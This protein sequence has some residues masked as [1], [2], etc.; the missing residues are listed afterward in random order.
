MPRSANST[1]L[2]AMVLVLGWAAS[3][4][5]QIQD[6]DAVQAMQRR[7]QEQ[8][9]KERLDRFIQDTFEFF[10]ISGE[11]VSFRVRQDLTD[12]EMEAIENRCRELDEQAGRMISYVRNVAPYVRGETAGL[13][14]VLDPL[15]EE[16]TLDERLTLI[17]ALVNRISPKIDQLITVLSEQL[18]PTIPVEELQLEVSAPFLIVGGLEELRSIA[19]DLRRTL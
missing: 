15:D 12:Q 16:S 3:S 17:L 7:A 19:R 5:A 8:Q 6:R 18:E 4:A 13:W 9:A 11:L 14:I 1:L 10:E 2:G